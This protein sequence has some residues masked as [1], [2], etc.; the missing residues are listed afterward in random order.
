MIL[1]G[2]AALCL[3][4]GTAGFIVGDLCAIPR[5]QWEA[6]KSTRG[7]VHRHSPDY[8]HFDYFGSDT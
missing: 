4:C 1:L 5:R 6:G 3:F 2:I 7:R 8:H